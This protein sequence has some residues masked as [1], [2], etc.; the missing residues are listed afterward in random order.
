MLSQVTV[1]MSLSTE[2][3]APFTREAMRG[4]KA[5]EDEENRIKRVNDIVT[6]IYTSAVA[7]AKTTD[8]TSYEHRMYHNGGTVCMKMPVRQMTKVPVLSLDNLHSQAKG[9]YIF[10]TTNMSHIIQALQTLFPDSLVEHKMIVRTQD[11]KI[12]D[13]SKMDDA[14]LLYIVEWPI[15][16]IVSIDWS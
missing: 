6:G 13:V 11:G 4:L 1:G 16:H 2:S 15:Q 9:Q 5:Q 12:H 7:Y 3:L 10:Y 14:A 8:A